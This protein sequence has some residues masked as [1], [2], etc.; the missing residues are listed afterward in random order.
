MNALRLPQTAKPLTTASLAACFDPWRSLEVTRDVITAAR[1]TELALHERVD[2]RLGALL[3]SAAASSP[4]YRDRLRGRN[5]ASFQDIEP[6]TKQELMRGFEQWVAD[7]RLQW[8]AVSAFLADAANLG[9]AFAGEFVLWESS[10]SSGAPAVFVQDAAAMAVYDALEAW[11][12]LQ[13][14]F[15][16]WY[17]GERIVFIG[18]T[19]GPF[20]STVTVERLRQVNPVMAHNLRSISLLQP[21]ADVV[22]QL[23]RARPTVLSTYPTV[24]VLLAREAAAGRL[25][26][27]VREVWTGGETLTASMRVLIEQQ[28]GCRVINSY[29]ASEFLA[30]A[31]PCRC[32]S[33]HVNSDWALLE[34]VDERHQPVPPGTT[35]HTCLL[36]N[37]ANHVQPIIRYDLGD[38]IRI[39]PQ[40]CPCG[41][42]FPVIEVEGRCD[43]M[44]ELRGEAGRPVMLL[45]L[46][47][48]TVMEEQG[49]LYDFQIV[50]VAPDRLELWSEAQ[51]P[52]MARARAA[53]SAYLERQ[54]AGQVAVTAVHR[55]PGRRGASGKFQRVVRI[56]S[57][58]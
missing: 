1:C 50:Q 37:L 15:D 20:A 10:G 26:L 9:R 23:H 21:T 28:F 16:P 49:G 47:M 57:P 42:R 56:G 19:G 35:S 39:V 11:R 4:V 43:D 5:V 25:R 36:T 8:P 51:A 38:R 22:A 7:P 44:L 58:R 54:G 53:L 32:G 14:A 40:A 18:A 46:A 30:L 41:S 12:R 6:V 17:F 13:R 29:G 2:R 55:A 34:A 31:S 33:L 27:S 24:A 52:S 48:T 45:P 3:A